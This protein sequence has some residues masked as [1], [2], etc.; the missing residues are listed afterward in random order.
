[1]PLMNASALKLVPNGPN[2]VRILGMVISVRCVML[3]HPL[4][5]QNPYPPEIAIVA[6]EFPSS[7][8]MNVHGSKYL[9]KL[10]ETQI[11]SRPVPLSECSRLNR[12]PGTRNGYSPG[13]LVN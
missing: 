9:T 13:S 8:V 6:I 5:V 2:S 7:G 12:P 3:A 11:C 1:M 10:F 4:V